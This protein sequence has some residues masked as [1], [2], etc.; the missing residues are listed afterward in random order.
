[1]TQ[2]LEGEGKL[3]FSGKMMALIFHN[4][5][6]RLI[7]GSGEIVES[8]VSKERFVLMQGLEI[9]AN[10]KSLSLVIKQSTSKPRLVMDSFF[11]I[12]LLPRPSH[13][14]TNKSDVMNVFTFI[15]NFVTLSS[16]NSYTHPTTHVHTIIFNTLRNAFRLIESFSR[17]LLVLLVD[18]DPNDS[19]GANS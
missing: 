18:H 5:Y 2:R 14:T 19:Q 17:V 12:N 16:Q 10:N 4:T 8:I 9:A 6:A 11:R 7:R 15:L 3:K 13:P 1:M